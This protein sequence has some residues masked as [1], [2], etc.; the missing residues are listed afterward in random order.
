MKVLPVAFDS[1]GA[2]SMATYVE[3]KDVKIFI[4]PAVA[5]SPD[6]TAS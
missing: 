2:R 4:D 1:F 6:T 3:T 5:L